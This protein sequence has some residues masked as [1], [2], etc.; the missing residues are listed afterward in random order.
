MD[1]NES[2][3]GENKENKDTQED[4]PNKLM[5]FLSK[6]P[7][8]ITYFVIGVAALIAAGSLILTGFQ[9]FYNQSSF[10]KEYVQALKVVTES[11]SSETYIADD[12]LLTL[13]MEYM[14]KLEQMH[15]QTS[16]S[17]LLVFTYDF[18]SSVLILVSATLV[19]R[20]EAQI[21]ALKDKAYK[22]NNRFDIE[23]R[24][25][26]KDYN[27][28]SIIHDR[29]STEA[30]NINQRFEAQ[31]A[32][33]TL[34]SISLTLS[35][36]L[37]WLQS[38]AIKPNNNSLTRFNMNIKTVAHCFADFE[39]ISNHSGIINGFE[40]ILGEVTTL[41]HYLAANDKEEEYVD[42]DVGHRKIID[43]CFGKIELKISE[44]KEQNAQN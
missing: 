26:G 39:P 13:R 1:N 43:K 16:S 31:E 20:G 9:F 17:D 41:Y 36:A 27:K 29:L 19:K 25:L 7:D 38:Y 5:S 14:E 42:L 6:I 21:K 37:F 12:E 3:V 24:K 8:G 34:N 10:Q 32:D 35:S 28:L 18:I 44:M 40:K 15:R 11:L 22:I 30:N 4:K 33:S 2:K 23:A